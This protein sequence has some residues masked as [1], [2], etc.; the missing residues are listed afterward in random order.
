[1]K[2]IEK[3]FPANVQI[4]KNEQGETIAT[5]L[6][7]PKIDGSLYAYLLNISFGQNGRTLINKALLPSLT[8]IGNIIGQSRYS[9]TT[10]NVVKKPLCRQT[11][12]AH[13]NYLIEKHYLFDQGE[14]YEI[15]NPENCY[16]SIPL[17]TLNFLTDTLQLEVIKTYLY[18]KQR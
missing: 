13:L 9:K 11:V 1:M 8:E 7:D 5:F 17:E 12:K 4:E 16:C 6:N 2:S 3:R 10:K 15:L 14:Y 18:L